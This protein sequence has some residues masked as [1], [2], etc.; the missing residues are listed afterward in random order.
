MAASSP[1]P[2]VLLNHLLL[3]GANGLMCVRA[4]ALL[5][6]GGRFKLFLAAVVGQIAEPRGALAGTA[7][8]KGQL[9]SCRSG[10]EPTGEIWSQGLPEETGMLGGMALNR[11]QALMAGKQ[12]QD[13]GAHRKEAPHGVGW[14][15]G[16]AE[17]RL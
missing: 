2:L 16:G 12:G 8:D 14:G 11:S 10:W 6:P 15:G 17:F 1:A 5:A 9:A 13:E 7:I 4:P 3:R